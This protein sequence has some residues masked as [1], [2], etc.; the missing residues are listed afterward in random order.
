[1]R[2]L[3][4]ASGDPFSRGHFVPGHF[5]ASSFVLSPERDALLLIL[6]S[7]L[8]RWLQP[9]GHVD[10]DDQS[11]LSAARRE[12]KEEVGLTGL[13]LALGPTIFDVDVHA[14]PPMRG[15]PAHQHFDVR[16]VFVAPDR[17]ATAGSDA[18]ATQW[19]ALGAVHTVETDDSVLRAVRKLR[20]LG[21]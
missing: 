11:I 7:K 21:G 5:T 4:E 20:A 9:G 6:H 16:F 10:P 14:I 8:K 18:L 17:A 12:V 2:S 1:M 19:V 3:I 13:P 15:E